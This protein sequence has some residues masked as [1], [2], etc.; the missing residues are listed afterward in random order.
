MMHLNVRR[1]DIYYDSEHIYGFKFFDKNKSLVWN[2][3]NLAWTLKVANVVLEEN[4]TIVGVAARYFN[5][6]N[7]RPVYTDF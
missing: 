3:G 1:V 2:I 4:E 6:R 5:K 7:T